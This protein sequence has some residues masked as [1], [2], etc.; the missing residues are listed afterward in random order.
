MR[1]NSNI[2]SFGLN[3][4]IHARIEILSLLQIYSQW[5]IWVGTNDETYLHSRIILIDQLL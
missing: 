3:K 1:Y 4:I 5:K 2:L